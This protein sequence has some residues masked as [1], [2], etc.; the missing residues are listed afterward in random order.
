M[1]ELKDL[2]TC[3]CDDGIDALLQGIAHGLKQLD[4]PSPDTM[5]E[6]LHTLLHRACA[7]CDAAPNESDTELA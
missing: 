2:Y 4:L 3:G 1:R 6:R 7:A 5:P